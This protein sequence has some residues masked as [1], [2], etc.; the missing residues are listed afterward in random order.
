MDSHLYLFA[1]AGCRTPA[2]KA[3]RD[4][5]R[6]RLCWLAHSGAVSCTPGSLGE[7][8]IKIPMKPRYWHYW[9]TA[10]LG[11]IVIPSLL[12]L[13]LPVRFDWKSLAIAYWLV[14]A[15]HSIFVAAILCLIGLPG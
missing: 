15:V 4:R 13:H 11:A 14:L 9:I 2:R 7:V 6:L 12:H 8:E 3:S 10:L 1:Y 5:K